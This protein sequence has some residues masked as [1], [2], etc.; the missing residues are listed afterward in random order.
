MAEKYSIEQKTVEN[1]LGTIR[2]EEIAIPEIQRP[3]VW[4]GTQVRDL[5][6]CKRVS[7]GAYWL[8]DRVEGKFYG[9]ESGKGAF[10]GPTT[11][12]AQ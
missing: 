10:V 12:V 11:A 1:I 9:N 2:N 3:F 4:S 6:P 5:V 7:D 8:Y